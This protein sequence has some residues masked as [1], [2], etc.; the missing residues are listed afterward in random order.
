MGGGNL[1]PPPP[2]QVGAPWC[3]ACW[4][5]R[6]AK[7]LTLLTSSYSNHSVE[8]KMFWQ[9]VG[10]QRCVFSFNFKSNSN[11]KSVCWQKPRLFAHCV[12]WQRWKGG[13]IFECHFYAAS[14]S[15]TNSIWGQKNLVDIFSPNDRRCFFKNLFHSCLYFAQFLFNSIY[16][17]QLFCPFT[18]KE[19]VSTVRSVW[20]IYCLERR[21]SFVYLLAWGH[22]TS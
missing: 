21:F 7:I 16:A 9:T 18:E 22:V 6:W 3:M 14:A 19:T 20:T 15:D 2:P 10:P 12:R 11:K 17:C 1:H 13:K 8:I 5:R 4:G